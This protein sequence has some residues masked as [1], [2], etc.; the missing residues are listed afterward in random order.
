MEDEPQHLVRNAPSLKLKTIYNEKLVD[1]LFIGKSMSGKLENNEI[2]KEQL[3]AVIVGI[4]NTKR[5]SDWY[6]NLALFLQEVTDSIP[7]KL[8][9]IGFALKF[10]YRCQTTPFPLKP[11]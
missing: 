8:D 9:D 10:S 4:G 7:S 3:N 2:L 1:S 11:I 5:A 6:R